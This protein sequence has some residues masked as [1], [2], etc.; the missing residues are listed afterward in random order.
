MTREEYLK[1]SRELH[2]QYYL[3]FATTETKKQVLYNIGTDRIKN[4]GNR[5]FNDIP[6]PEWDR[7]SSFMVFNEKLC[8]EINGQVSLSDRVCILKAVAE[9]IRRYL[10]GYK[11]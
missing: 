8:R 9:N 6:L 4:S 2:N 10:S 1:N 3:Q 5:H 11:F 7:L